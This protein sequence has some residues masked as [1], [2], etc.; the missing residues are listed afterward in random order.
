MHD[1]YALRPARC[2]VNGL[3]MRGITISRLSATG[4]V[5]AGALLAG[6][7]M[8][9]AMAG[10]ADQ[11]QTPEETALAMP[12]VKPP[13]GA[14]GL[15]LPQPLPPSEAARI[16]RIFALQRGGDIPSA[17]AETAR[18]TDDTLL[19]HILADR[20]L[21]RATR[22]TAPELSDWLG[23]Y[24]DL[25][26]ASAVYAVLLK[27][28]P[29]GAARPAPPAAGGLASAAASAASQSAAGPAR[30]AF[31]RG[32]DAVALRL[33]RDA[34]RRSGGKD[35]QAAYVAGL[36]AWRS[37]DFAT[38]RTMFEA[39]AGAEGAGAAL[40]AAS[41]FWA[42]RAHL[43][44]GDAAGW[45]PWMLRA[46]AEP[47][48]LHGMLARRTL[49]LEEP[50][51]PQNFT[52]GQADIDSVA[53]TPHGRRA[54]A[55]LQVGEPARAEAE[56]RLLW[57]GTVND[58]PLTRAILLVARA[59]GL[60]ALVTDISG[61]L[62]IADAG[63]PMP[64]LRPRGGFTLNPAL[65]YAVARVESNFDPLAGSMNDAHGLMQLR[66]EVAAIFSHETADLGDPGTNLK[67]GQRYLTYLSSTAMAGD[68]LLHV[69]AAYNAGPGA[70][71]R[72]KLSGD[73]PLLFLEALPVDETRRY[74]QMT[75]TYLW[76][77]AARLGLPA[78]SL[79]AMAA[80]AWPKFSAEVARLH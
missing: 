20:L 70:V 25:P 52:M 13:A 75:L 17:V 59:A 62:H 57:P 60:N 65:V 21:R 78:P 10:G 56:L 29:S 58:A 74:V 68:D 39:A 46:A 35:G 45:R 79:D 30:D 54:F 1:N 47:Q 4:A 11:A 53:A 32:R 22:A 27:K 24:A 77:Y 16:R 15:G 12:R 61:V 44:S 3:R 80:G 73:D 40:R 55:L 41:A 33:G 5:L 8:R 37:E 72:W 69:L 18:L 76:S 64:R 63:K 67:I 36:A 38:A 48:M 71:Q 19:G 9:P 34:W 26:D 66:P 2:P 51:R 50:V 7:S 31:A 28:L 49:G 14:G 43:R 23:R 42:A 6:A